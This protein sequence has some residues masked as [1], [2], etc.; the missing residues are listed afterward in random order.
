MFITQRPESSRSPSTPLEP[1]PAAPAPTSATHERE[2]L[3]TETMAQ[4]SPDHNITPRNP[5]FNNDLTFTPEDPE[6]AYFITKSYE[7]A[8][9]VQVGEEELLIRQLRPHFTR[10]FI[11]D[12]VITIPNYIHVMY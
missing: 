9:V 3:E 6:V 4:P 8:K 12:S 10:Q 11:H 7:D 1:H 2:I 5:I